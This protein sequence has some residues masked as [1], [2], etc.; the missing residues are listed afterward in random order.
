MTNIKDTLYVVSSPNQFIQSVKHILTNYEDA[1]KETLA[2]A[3][4]FF[5][6]NTEK[7]FKEFFNSLGI[8]Q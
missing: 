6:P 1:S 2:I 3:K 5:T 7:N 8:L 4:L